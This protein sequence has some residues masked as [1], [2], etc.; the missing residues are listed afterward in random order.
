MGD[1]SL[2]ANMA[3]PVQETAFRVPYPV[4]TDPEIYRREQ[5][6]IFRGD[7]W[8][9]VALEAEI[10]NPG[11]FKSTYI[12]DSPVVV[13]R[14]KD[15]AIHVVENRCAHR[16]AMVC[17][18]LRGNAPHL[19][20]VYHQWAY[21]L[22][23]KLMGVPFRRGL[24]GQGGMPKDFD[25][26]RHNLTQL[27]VDTIGGLVFATFSDAV[28][29]LRDYLGEVGTTH[30]ERICN[31]PLKVLGDQRQHVHGNWKLYAENV[32]DPYHAS[33]LHLFHTT[34]GLYRSTQQGGARMDAARRHSAI[35]SIAASN[36]DESDTKAYAGS[37]T[38]NSEFSLKDMS[39][40]KGRPEFND[41]ITLVI[42]GIFPNLVLQQISNTLAVRHIVT[43]GPDAF[44]LVWTHFGYADDDAEM[45]AIRVMQA[46]L[47]GPAG[48]ISMEDG[49]A[50]EIVQN[51]IGEAS[52]K[53]S[54]IAMGGGSS[55]DVDHL[56]S[57][58]TII[59]FWE[60][61]ERVVGFDM[62]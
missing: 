7:N 43:H 55:A 56:V 21:E 6:K 52:D 25:M 15:G 23:G 37:R 20:C 54:F 29:P 22:N 39:L 32:R 5:R 48:L 36:N 16:G 53:R 4:F 30:I 1:V 2:E 31:R 8:S 9:F 38:F 18:E 46:N 57:E 33:L 24:K 45:D 10:P 50:V 17:R 58:G 11:D 61:Y 27:R 47:I 59:G 13:T 42:L 34:F 60:N 40:L 41:G 44:E 19:E 3:S 49:E 26:S 12:G 51:A 28:E 35:Y 62:A 14:S